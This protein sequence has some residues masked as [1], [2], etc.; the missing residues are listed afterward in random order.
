M[1]AL[2]GLDH[3]GHE[4]LGVQIDHGGI[5]I[6]IDDHVADR[7]HQV[8]LAEPHATVDEQRVVAPAGIFGH[9]HGGGASEL[10]G[11]ALDE[12][13]EGEVGIECAVLTRVP[14]SAA[15]GFL[16]LF[17]D[18]GMTADFETDRYLFRTNWLGASRRRPSRVIWAWRGRIQ[19]LNCCALSSPSR[20]SRH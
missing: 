6:V 13:V 3:L 15:G 16:R 14:G 1:M 8:G 4:T 9:L 19:V 2:Q 7:M 12:G 20:R 17:G 10:V 18:D 11:L 5:G